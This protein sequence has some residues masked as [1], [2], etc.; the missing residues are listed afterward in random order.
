M[1]ELSEL[2]LH[3]DF[4]QKARQLQDTAPHYHFISRLVE[5][6]FLI[7]DAEY[8]IEKAHISSDKTKCIILGAQKY[9]TI[10]QNKLLKVIEEP[11][12]GVIFKLICNTKTTILPTILS[13]LPIN[14]CLDH[15]DAKRLD[16][17][18]FGL[19]HIYTLLK[20]SK[21]IR[22][23]EAQKMIESYTKEAL[24]H[25]DFDF[26]SN[27]YSALEQM[28]ALLDRG[29]PPLFVLNSALLKLLAIKTKTLKANNAGQT[30]S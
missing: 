9:S 28:I 2:I 25:K 19:E 22:A 1:N 16:L 30:A 10:A 27:D 21:A 7:E 6:E 5:G 11:P 26:K 8:V 13:R 15:S 20:Q 18:N 3:R 14:N 12:R 24:L 17:Q 23:D 4:E 29:S